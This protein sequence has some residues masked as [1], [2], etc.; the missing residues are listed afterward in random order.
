MPDQEPAPRLKPGGPTAA[1][2]AEFLG[3][4]PAFLAEHPHLLP[5]LTP[6][7]AR[8][9]EPVLDFQRFAMARLQAEL[10]LLR[11]A[12][13]EI[14]GAGRANLSAQGRIHAAA[15]A[16]LG[17]RTLEHLIEIVTDDIAVPLE[18]D[19]IVLGFEAQDLTPPGGGAR[20]LKLFAKGRIDRWI[21][22]GRD[23][24]LAGPVEADPALFA[25]AATLVQSQALL[26]LQ[27][28]REAPTGILAL[29]SRDA[30]KFAPGQGTELLGFLG[31]VVELAIRG[32]LDR[33]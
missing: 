30:A 21:P 4:H 2:I 13:D 12:H 17:A 26:R 5:L 3:R 8:R 19:A 25:G 20:G 33:G 29:G 10:Q 6:P 1:E 15:I 28:R 22:T 32:W 24:L 16:V 7:E 27:L 23:V 14:V 11:R 31:H 18:V 9:G